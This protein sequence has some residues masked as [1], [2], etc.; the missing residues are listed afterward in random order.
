MGLHHYEPNEIT[1]LLSGIL[2]V[3]NGAG[4]L[5]S[6]AGRG[7]A[8]I[9]YDLNDNPV[10]IQFTDGS[11][12]RY[13]YS[14]AG[15]ELR[16]THQTAVP[17]ITVAIGSTRELLPSEVLNADSVDYLLGGSLTMR[18][19][20]I[21][22]FL[23]D[24]GYCQAT[25][26]VRVPSQDNFTFYYYDRDHLGSIRQV[27]KADGSQGNIV[28]SM[29]YYPFGAQWCDGS[30]DNNFQPYRYNGKE[31]DKMHGLN[32]YD[33][34]ARQYNPVLGRWD[35]V[36]PLCEK[37]YDVSPY[38]YCHNNPTN[39][40]DL[41]GN[42]DFFSN[43]GRFLY[44]KG[45]GA[46]IFIQQGNSF[47]NLKNFDLR[48]RANRQMGANVVGHYAHVVGAD[49]NYNG[50]DGIIGISTL[51]KTD[52][53]AGV[54]G[55]TI[56][57]NI[58]IKFSNGYFNE[59]LYNKYNLMGVLIHEKNHKKDQ[60]TG[61]F[62]SNK[63]IPSSRHARIII[64]EMSSDNFP[65]CSEKYQDGQMGYLGSLAELV[66]KTNPT[67][68]KKIAKEANQALAKIG[69][70]MYYRKGNAYFRIIK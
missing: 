70:E 53:E 32:T 35:R 20:R 36:D 17:N 47:S 46:N 25:K 43:T 58:Y 12:T 16:V 66:L 61:M 60:Q 27:I 10:R 13:V 33:Y 28:Q 3:H 30:T 42:D 4:S 54:L 1:A 5:V 63:P 52:I 29:D 67:D 11:V 45:K 18:N 23:F 34:G 62:P 38:V 19:G 49:R 44:T 40:V 55:G 26:Y 51:H 64:N 9:D 14:A 39:R 7:I 2:Y 31:L 22:K 24:E 56:N 59:E 65:N 69:W 57:G 6:D 8:R 41:D 48:N 50:K 68:A 37:Y 21:D 15:E